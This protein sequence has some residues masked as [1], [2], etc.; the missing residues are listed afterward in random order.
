MKCFND[1]AALNMH[2]PHYFFKNESQSVSI[3]FYIRSQNEGRSMIPKASLATSM[4]EKAL[5]T[6]IFG[7]AKGPIHIKFNLLCPWY[8]TGD[9]IR[10]GTIYDLHFH[11]T[12]LES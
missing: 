3:Q 12:R 4:S 5:G 11:Y 2:V 9:M 10:Q 7:S 1:G 6:T 8:K